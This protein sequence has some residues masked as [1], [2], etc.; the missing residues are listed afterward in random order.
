MGTIHKLTAE[1]KEFIVKHKQE[2]AGISCRQ[3]T[4]TITEKF[5]VKISKS[6]INALFKTAGLSQPI[7]RRQKRPRRKLQ[8]PK[9]PIQLLEETTVQQPLFPVAENAVPA[10][11]IPS[12]HAMPVI[13]PPP[14]VEAVPLPE[15]PAPIPVASALEEIPFTLPLV[16]GPVQEPDSA[17][18][19]AMAHLTGAEPLRIV[20]AIKVIFIDGSSFYLDGQLRSLWPGPDAPYKLAV[21][22]YYA[23]DYVQNVFSGRQPL[24]LLTAPGEKCPNRNFFDFIRKIEENSN[25]EVGLVFFGNDLEE[26]GG[27]RIVPEQSLTCIVSLWPWQFS[28]YRRVKLQTGFLPFDFP[29]FSSPLYAGDVEVTLSQHTDNE[30]VTIRGAALK[31]EPTAKI[32]LIALATS[33]TQLSADKLLASYLNRWPNLEEGIHYHSQNVDLFTY[34]RLAKRSFLPEAGEEY[35]RLLD[36]YF[37]WFFLP[38]AQE[39]ID[40]PTINQHFYQLP[41]AQSS[42]DAQTIIRFNPGPAHPFPEALRHACRR[43]NEYAVKTPSCGRLWFSLD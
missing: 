2:N 8:L 37:R 27:L 40:S 10:E 13:Q 18:L 20:R 31:T 38:P 21:S 23:V 42:K 4:R 34:T 33:T 43:L 12:G 29:L 14:V 7:G 15:A 22:L 36:R 17:L 11:G 39:Q 5:Q 26:L 1:I 32:R 16:S 28:Q 6:S 41:S 25:K 19:N 30:V 3:L 24:V 35:L 9:I